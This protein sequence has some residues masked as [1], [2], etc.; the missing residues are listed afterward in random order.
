MAILSM[1][2]AILGLCGLSL[3]TGIPAILLG[4][5]AH[6]SITISGG[7]LKGKGLALGG[8]I[9]GY[10]DMAILLL[11]LYNYYFVPK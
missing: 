11:F 6:H 8:L 2:L 3:F 9:L 4:H 10:I 7:H 1:V 5:I